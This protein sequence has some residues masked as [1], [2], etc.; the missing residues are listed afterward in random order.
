MD[1]GNAN[2]WPEKS[3]ILQSTLSLEL[4]FEETDFSIYRENNLTD[5]RKIVKSGVIW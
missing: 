2:S 3:D 1:C 4:R 5:S